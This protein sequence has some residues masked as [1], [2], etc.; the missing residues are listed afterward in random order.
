MGKGQG[1]MSRWLAIATITACAVVAPLAG[2]AAAGQAGS[3]DTEVLATLR[4]ENPAVEVKAKG[5]DEFEPATDGQ[6]L[7]QGDTV[8]TDGTG[9]AEVDYSDD[10]YT[11]L[12]VNT[13]FKIVKLTEEQGERQVEGGLETGRTW[14]RTEAI[15][16]S[17]AFEQSGGG[18]TAAVTGTAF[19]VDCTS[20]SGECVF[21]GVEGTFILK[22]E[23]EDQTITPFEQCDSTDGDLCAQVTTLTIEE[24]AAITWIQENLL[25]DLLKRG[26]GNGPFKVSGV[27]VVEDGVVVDFIEATPPPGA[28][29]APS[30]PTGGGGGGVTHVI[31]LSKPVL[32]AD[33]TSGLAFAAAPTCPPVMPG[34]TPESR[35]VVTEGETVLFTAN[36]LPGV[37]TTGL[38]IVFTGIDGGNDFRICDNSS[39]ECNNIEVGAEYDVTTVFALTAQPGSGGATGTFAFEIR[40]DDVVV[41]GPIAVPVEIEDAVFEAATAAATTEPEPEIATTQT[42]AVPEPHDVRRATVPQMRP[43]TATTRFRPTARCADGRQPRLIT[44]VL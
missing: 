11:R 13:T 37:D 3:G 17:G 15:T 25:R 24:M 14:N 9:R 38:T 43:Q 7:R 30:T 1:F 22:G 28:P 44:A 6:S 31:D 39:Q 8:R 2:V 27:L 10:T 5:A 12:D 20:S 16:Q 41:D 4:V 32:V 34:C 23:G 29:G 33:Q 42:A 21:T 36:L 18:A 26:L 19:P 40:R 35:I